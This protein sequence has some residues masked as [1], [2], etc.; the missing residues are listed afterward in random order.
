MSFDE[1]FALRL[2]DFNYNFPMDLAHKLNFV[3]LQF[4]PDLPWFTMIQFRP[5]LPCTGK[6]ITSITGTIYCRGKSVPAV[7]VVGIPKFR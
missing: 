7:S 3:L 2:T 4:S 5:D 1:E 6:S